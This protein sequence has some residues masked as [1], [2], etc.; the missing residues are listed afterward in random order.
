MRK[1]YSADGAYMGDPALNSD[2]TAWASEII[3]KA[4]RALPMVRNLI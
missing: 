1:I 2:W 4:I 3:A